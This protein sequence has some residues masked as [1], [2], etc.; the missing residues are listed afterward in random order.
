MRCPRELARYIAHKGS[1]NVDGTS[2]VNAVNGAEQADHRP[3]YAQRNHHGRV[4]AGRRVNLEVD[5]LAHYLERLLLANKAA[6]ANASGISEAF[7]AENG[8]SSN[9][10]IA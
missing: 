1:I 5:L 2:L 8:F 3:A 7:L 10:R 6:Q 4:P 9:P